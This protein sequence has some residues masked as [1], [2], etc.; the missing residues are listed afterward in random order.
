M[1]FVAIN[2]KGEIEE[3]IQVI[4]D[5]QH[6]SVWGAFNI[7][8]TK[9]LVPFSKK[10]L[11]YE[12][13]LNILAQKYDTLVLSKRIVD[14][15]SQHIVCINGIYH[16]LDDKSIIRRDFGKKRITFSDSDCNEII[17]SPTPYTT[18]P[19]YYD[20]LTEIQK[21]HLWVGK[22]IDT[23]LWCCLDKDGNVVSQSREHEDATQKAIHDLS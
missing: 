15:D 4:R 18:F 2:S 1:I 20:N 22:D 23:G 21:D 11:N 8:G 14:K 19:D 3:R 17:E 13:V 10:H 12:C 16:L 7:D 6:Q 5:P 9:V